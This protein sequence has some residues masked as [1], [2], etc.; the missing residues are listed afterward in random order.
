MYAALIIGGSIIVVGL[1]L[2]LHHRFIGKKSSVSTER[3]EE[4]S[5]PKD[6]DE[7]C[8]MHITCERDSLSPV[9]AE[10]VIYYDD[11]EL[12]VFAGK[13]IHDYTDSDI[14][15][16]RDVLLTLL[17]EDIGGWARSIQLRGINLPSSVKDELMMIVSEERNKKSIKDKNI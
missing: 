6:E 5:L 15:M 4:S 13:D 2:Y 12:D 3:T 11:E 9:F 1:I 14:E 10:E 8:G 7:C 17:P 16:F